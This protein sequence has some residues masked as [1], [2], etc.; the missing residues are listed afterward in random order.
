MTTHEDSA[1]TARRGRSRA[2]LAVAVVSSILIVSVGQLFMSGLYAQTQQREPERNAPRG[3]PLVVGIARTP[4]GPGEWITYVRALERVQGALG[5]PVQI[6]YVANR[7]DVVQLVKNQDVDLAFVPTY[8]YIQLVRADAGRIVAAPIVGGRGRET[9]VVVVSA[10][11]SAQRL[12]DLRGKSVALADPHSLGGYSFVLWTLTRAG[13][14]PRAYFSKV[15]T[16]LSQDENLSRVAAGDV[17]S[18]CVNRSALATWPDETFR[19]VA[20]SPQYGMPPLVARPGLSPDVVSAVRDVLV[21][22][23]P[24]DGLPQDSA[25]DGF[26]H[27][28]AEDYEFAVLLADYANTVEIVNTPQEGSR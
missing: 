6:R 11:S 14:N 22:L 18:T 13:E 7:A 5:R 23:K 3:D 26:T 28:S 20:E 8:R 12:E 10:K 1:A 16:G 15:E 21:G 27:P 9:A 25:I 17:S 2:L 19:V 24:G 4:G